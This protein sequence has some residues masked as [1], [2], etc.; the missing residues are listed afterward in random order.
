MRGEKLPKHSGPLKE[1]VA[2]VKGIEDPGPLR[3][4]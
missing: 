4:V 2:E 3:G 1:D